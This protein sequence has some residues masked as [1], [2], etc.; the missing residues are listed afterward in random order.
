MF[1]FNPLINTCY[2]GVEA[3]S[4]SIRNVAYYSH[5]IPIFFSL[6]LAILVF[7]KSLKSMLSKIFFAFTIVFSLWLTADLITWVSNNYYLVYTF[8]A[9]VDYIETLM[10][11]LGLYFVLVFINKKDIRLVYKLLLFLVTL[12]PLIIT[13]T[14]NSVLGFNYPVC[15][16]I[17]NNFLLQY[18]FYVEV[19]VV[20]TILFYIIKTLIKNSDIN[21]KSNLVVLFSMFLFLTIFG[22]TSYLSAVT[23]YYEL[24]L[25]ALFIIPAFLISIIYSI[26]NLDIFN[27]KIVSTYFIVFGFVI[28]MI[29]QLIFLTSTTNKLLTVLT[30]II[31]LVLSIILFKN[32]KKESDQRIRIEKLSD[33]IEQS[34]YRLEKSNMQLEIANDKLKDLDKLKTE[35]VSLVSHQLRS[36]L[37]AIKGYT[38]MLMEGDYGDVTPKEKEIIERILESSNN[39]ALVVEDLLNVT[40]I[41][42]GGMKYEM[43]KF[44]FGVM[45]LNTIKDLSIIAQNKG[46]KLINNI[47]TSQNYFVNGD[48]EKLR[49]V[50]IN[51]FD[52]SMKYTKEGQ[53]EVDIKN[54]EGKILLMIKDSGAG[55]SKEVIG[56]LFHKFSRGDEA[57]LNIAGSG[58][59]LYLV[60]EIIDAH[61]GRVWIESEGIGHGSTFFVE[62]DEVK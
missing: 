57:R 33:E 9:P 31:S 56:T 49:Q 37:T 30:I 46:L 12:I 54:N 4:S 32:L 21:N 28:L 24:N 48:K 25:Y 13:I 1:E 14:Q 41:E 29:F 10:F 20:T 39:L 62:L 52:N 53:I 61:K 15:E 40:K 8:W 35:F 59:G 23:T 27:L 11:I 5:L 17:N 60:K 45:V 7:I 36:P 26:F 55:I 43:E 58:L 6:F 50:L 51:L 47:N 42:Q 44:D 2:L 16:A 19:F 3:I 22:V 18:R 38:S 34:K